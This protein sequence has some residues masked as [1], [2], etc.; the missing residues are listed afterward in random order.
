MPLLCWLW[1]VSIFSGQFANDS[2]M[3]R[4][5]LATG[6]RQLVYAYT[7]DRYLGTGVFIFPLSGVL[8][9]PTS[10]SGVSSSSPDICAE[11]EVGWAR[12]CMGVLL[13]DVRKKP[14]QVIFGLLI[15]VG[16]SAFLGLAC[17]LVCEP[18]KVLSHHFIA[19]HNTSYT[20]HNHFQ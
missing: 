11:T 15:A 4:A 1:L 7:G 14:L 5:L 17:S 20:L 12:M 8:P 2:E 19:R 13:S 16:L 10:F 18:K 3:G 6:H 9:T